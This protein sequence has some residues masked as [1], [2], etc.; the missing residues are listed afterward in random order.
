L[1]SGIVI[2]SDSEAIQAM[3]PPQSPS[4]DCFNLLAITGKRLRTRQMPKFAANLSFLYTDLPLLDR[5]GAAARSGFKGVEYMS[6][7]E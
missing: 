3:P 5:I 6:P 1:E 2:A 7:Y 4:L